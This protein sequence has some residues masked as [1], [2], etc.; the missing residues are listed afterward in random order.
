MRIPRFQKKHLLQW[1]NTVNEIFQKQYDHFSVHDAL[2]S[3]S[4]LKE[5]NKSLFLLNDRCSVVKH[6][7]ILFYCFK[8]NK[9][10]AVPKLLVSLISYDNLPEFLH[11]VKLLKFIKSIFNTC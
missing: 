4:K 3:F 11:V 2:K 6:D 5:K 10:S 9:I 8:Y 7:C 1:K